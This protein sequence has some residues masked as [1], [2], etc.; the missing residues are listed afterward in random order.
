M[1]ETIR[2]F[3]SIH[4]I[5]ADQLPFM[6]SV[7]NG[8]THARIS[9]QR[10]IET[11]VTAAVLG[12]LGYVAIIPRLEE[13]VSIESRQVQKDIA[14]L[15]GKVEEISARRDADFRDLVDRIDG[16]KDRRR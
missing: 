13:R 16:W 1:M 8:A 7:V 5:H 14:E 6:M 4:S 12:G 11:A 10:L 9:M 2:N 3:F 15:K